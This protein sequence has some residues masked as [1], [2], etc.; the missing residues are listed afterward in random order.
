MGAAPFM[1]NLKGT[2]SAKPASGAEKATAARSEALEPEAHDEVETP[3][4]DFK[5]TRT[6]GD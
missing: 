3:S 2:A 5:V 4:R 6:E 1:A